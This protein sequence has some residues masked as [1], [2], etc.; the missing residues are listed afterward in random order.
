[1]I[2][3]VSDIFYITDP[4]WIQRL[5]MPRTHCEN[6]FLIY[7]YLLA[8]TAPTSLRLRRSIDKYVQV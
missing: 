4:A 8:T 2:D 6:D 5:V 3:P 1:M 7:A